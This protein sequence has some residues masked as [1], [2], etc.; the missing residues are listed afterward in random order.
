MSNGGKYHNSLGIYKKHVYTEFFNM[1][2]EFTE[3][4]ADRIVFQINNN[5]GISEH[6][7][8]M[9]NSNTLML[10]IKISFSLQKYLNEHIK[11]QSLF[12]ADY[13]YN[14]SIIEPFLKFSFMEVERLG[15]KRK[16]ELEQEQEKLLPSGNTHM[17]ED[18]EDTTPTIVPGVENDFDMLSGNAEL[19]AYNGNAKGGKRTIRRK[20]PIKCKKTIRRKKNNRHKT[21][22]LKKKVKKYTVKKYTV[23]KYTDKK[24]TDKN[25][26][27]RINI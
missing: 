22:K 3:T 26:I 10:S 9:C 19:P 8:I 11:E 23:K 12:T 21:R 18:E 24:Y 15:R 16:A 13:K 20:K 2:D 27:N 25:Y 5:D 1:F 6:I 17:S 14:D 7:K 4:L